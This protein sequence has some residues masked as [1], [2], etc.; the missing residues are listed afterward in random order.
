MRLA[1][2]VRQAESDGI[3]W[4]PVRSKSLALRGTKVRGAISFSLALSL[5]MCRP[6]P[7]VFLCTCLPTACL[8]AYLNCSLP[9]SLRPSL[10]TPCPPSLS[11]SLALSLANPCKLAPSKTRTYNHVSSERRAAWNP[12]AATAAGASA[13]PICTNLWASQA[14]KAT[15]ATTY[16]PIPTDCY[17]SIG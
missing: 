17:L 6:S 10:P 15:A 13:T 12:E 7:S 8:S 5:R 16:L 4:P 9:P 3:F 2:C 14:F 1:R 11:I